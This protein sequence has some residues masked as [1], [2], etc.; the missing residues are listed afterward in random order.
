[1]RNLDRISGIIFF[2]L[3]LGI[4]LKSLTYPMGSLSG[5]GAGL[6]PL[7]SSIIVMGL[8]GLMTAQTFLKKDTG[9]ASKARFFPSKETPT[10]IFIA[11]MAL[12]GFRY[13]LPIIGFGIST[14]IFIFFL[15]KFVGHFSWKVSIFFSV[16]AG[17]VAY[18]LFQVF[19]KIPFPRSI[20]GV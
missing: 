20:L 3:G 9:E 11:F 8:S 17:L 19:L 18:Y 4:C 1:M 6:F 13:L 2:L 15:V 14:F 12:L 16:L 7:L 5:P 10:R